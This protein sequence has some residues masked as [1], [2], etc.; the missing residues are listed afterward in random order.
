MTYCYNVVNL[1]SEIAAGEGTRSSKRAGG[2][3]HGSSCRPH[4]RLA[5]IRPLINIGITYDL[6]T[7]A[8]A[9][10]HLP[11]DSQEEFDSPHT[12]EAIAREIRALGH[13][14]IQLGDGRAFLEKVLADPPDF[15]F[16]FAE[17][18]GVSRSR[19]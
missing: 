7:S 10:S 19:E 3:V 9:D 2:P 11:D 4:A 15:V 6:K 18:T 1:E 17:G 14:V 5:E 13:Q 16:N 12:L 8:A